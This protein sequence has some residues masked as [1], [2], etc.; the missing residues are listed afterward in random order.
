M[1]QIGEFRVKVYSTSEIKI[2][3]QGIKKYRY[4][5]ISIRDPRLD[6]HIGKT[7]IAR[8]FLVDEQ[9]RS[10]QEKSFGHQP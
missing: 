9:P 7:V 6:E 5:S 8:I 4:G 3:K 2:L 10:D 1:E